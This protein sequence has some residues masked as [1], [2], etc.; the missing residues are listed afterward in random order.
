MLHLCAYSTSTKIYLFQLAQ[1]SKN[2]QMI[3]NQKNQFQQQ[4]T[5]AREELRKAH[6]E[7]RKNLLEK[8]RL[9]QQVRL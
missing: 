9:Q 7:A 1:L 6:E 8:T 5:N 2:Q 3:V 4:L